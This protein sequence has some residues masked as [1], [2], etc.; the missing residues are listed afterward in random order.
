MKGAGLLDCVAVGVLFESVFTAG[1]VTGW[2][3]VGSNVIPAGGMTFGVLI[4]SEV[5]TGGIAV[6][7]V[8]G[9]DDIPVAA[10]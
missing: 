4:G 2:V 3:L 7:V 1:G 9:S 8:V 5:T 10:Q 6:G